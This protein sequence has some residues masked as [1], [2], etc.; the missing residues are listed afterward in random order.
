[1]KTL[2]LDIDET[3][4]HSLFDQHTAVKF[5]F[6]LKLDVG[7]GNTQ[8]VYVKKRPNVIE[9]LHK[10]SAHF[11]IVLWT[12]SMP[13][14]AQPLIRHL[15]TTNTLVDYCLFR[16]HCT[17]ISSDIYIKDLSKLGRDLA[18][19]IIVDNSN[20]SYMYQPQNALPCTSWMTDPEDNELM[21]MLPFL[22]C[23]SKS[24]DVRADLKRVLNGMVIP[25]D[26]T[27]VNQ[28]LQQQFGSKVGISPMKLLKTKYEV[29]K[30]IDEL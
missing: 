1:M 2:V 14:Y 5:D 16:E 24:R 18:N 9:F 30:N 4:I 20:V 21:D 17:Q 29:P 19:V 26:Y 8:K 28:V 22:M 23:L 25:Y 13:K 27:R 7:N 3:L 6:L 12:A 15:D 11:E 10:V